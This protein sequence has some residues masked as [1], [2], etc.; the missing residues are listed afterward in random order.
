MKGQSVI[1]SSGNDS[2]STPAGVYYDLDNEFNFNYDPC[3]LNK[4]PKLNYTLFDDNKED[5]IYNGLIEDWGSST[6]CNPPYS[7]VSK[8][9]EKGYNEYKKGKTVVFLVPSRT[10]TKWFHR[11]VLPYAKEI[12]FCKGRLK[13]GDAKNSAPFPSMIIIFK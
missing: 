6:F 1:F 4:T 3:P 10:D 12:R 5:K 11:F 7:E 9:I 8:W 13:F 2:W